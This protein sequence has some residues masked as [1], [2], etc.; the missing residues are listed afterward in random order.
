MNIIQ[1]LKTQVLPVDPE[2]VTDELFRKKRY[3]RFRLSLFLA[4][5]L[6]GLIPML[7]IA[8]LGYFQYRD[9]LQRNELDQLQWNMEGAQKT[10]ESFVH[11]LQAVVNFVAHDDRYN[12][13]LD[14]K[15][16]QILFDRI[17]KQY[18][19]FVSLGVIDSHGIQQTYAGPYNLQGEDYSQEKWFAD[20]LTKKVVI[21]DVVMGFSQAPVNCRGQHRFVEY[22]VNQ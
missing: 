13:L 3:K 6:I 5:N 16:L 4:M 2:R 20:V 7:L 19:Y 22:H 17:K 15:N 21:S 18:P 8:G 1:R 11:E 12:E 14:Q 10:L 9:L